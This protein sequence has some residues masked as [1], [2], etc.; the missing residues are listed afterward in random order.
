MATKKRG[1]PSEATAC[2]I[3]D[4]A[5][6]TCAVAW[7]DQGLTWVQLPEASRARLRG[8]LREHLGALHER[9]PPAPI[10]RAIRLVKQHLGG[11]TADFGATKLDMS[12]VPPFARR[13]YDALRQV[14]AGSTVS[15]GQLA[16]Q[17]GSP[18][19]AQAVGGAMARNPWP[20]VV[21]C[22][23]VLAADGGLGG[24]SAHGG[25]ATKARLLA[26]EGVAVPPTLKGCA[27]PR[28]RPVKRENRGLP[29]P[30]RSG[31][32]P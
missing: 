9:K 11:K 25:T 3:F 7:S 27:G 32:C 15:Y 13:V 31:R 4:T 23:R 18:G 29:L 22:H 21:P 30:P 14:E 5:I 12:S 20:L 16:A 1:N 2:T 19:A 26:I 8:R 24:F 10:G 17:I 28:A 6:G